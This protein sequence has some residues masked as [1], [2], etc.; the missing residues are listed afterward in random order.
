MKGFTITTQDGIIIKF[1]YYLAEAPVS[2]DAFHGL[3]PFSCTC[4]HARVSG[5]E[6]W[7]DNMPP[8]DIIQ[9]NASVF[10][11]PGEVVLGP[12]T[13]VRTKTANCFGIYYGEGKGLDAANIFAKVRGE[14]AEQLK[15][16][17]NRIWKEGGME[18]TIAPIL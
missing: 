6:I 11:E 18:I 4:Y 15:I 14:D 13:P 3:L 17:G 10:T 9:E 16:L 2:C 1:D 8:L 12:Q 7:M 5:E